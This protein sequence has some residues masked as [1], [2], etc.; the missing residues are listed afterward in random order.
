MSKIPFAKEA[1]KGLFKPAVTERY[2]DAPANVPKDFRG[3]IIFHADR[4]IGCGMCVRV[5]CPQ[6]IEQITKVIEDGKEITFRFDMG[7]C[8]FCGLCSDFCSKNAIELTEEYSIV[9]GSGEKC[10]V[11]GTVFRKSP[12]KKEIPKK[13]E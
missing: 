10:I 5:C 1:I 2:P 4:C 13:T 11:E 7:S 3:K 6:S 8:T 12:P 9:L